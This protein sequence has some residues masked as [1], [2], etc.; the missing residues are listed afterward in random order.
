MKGKIKTQSEEGIIVD[1][2]FIEAFIPAALTMDKST[3]NEDQESWIWRF[4]DQNASY[5]L[6][7]QTGEEIKF[8]VFSTDFS[9]PLIT[10]ADIVKI[11]E[12]DENGLIEEKS[13]D[14]TEQIITK[15]RYTVIGSLKNQGLG[16]KSWWSNC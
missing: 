13:D 5:D 8:S 14:E 2:G 9:K 15:F 12:T 6:E 4:Q 3:Y 10:H 16:M 11:E 1:L 7:Y